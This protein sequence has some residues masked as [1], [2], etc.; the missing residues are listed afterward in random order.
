MY[1]NGILSEAG[2]HNAFEE[3]GE[4]TWLGDFDAE[5]I[6]AQLP[7]S[8][9]LEFD[10]RF[11]VEGGKLI[12]LTPALTAALPTRLNDPI[13]LSD[14]REIIVPEDLRGLDWRASSGV[15]N[16]YLVAVRF[17]ETQL[18]IHILRI[19][20]DGQ[21]QFSVV[22]IALN[23]SLNTTTAPVTAFRMAEGELGNITLQSFL[24]SSGRIRCNPVVF[25]QMESDEGGERI[26]IRYYGTS[27]SDFPG[28][29]NIGA[30]VQGATIGQSGQW[31]VT[32]MDNVEYRPDPPRVIPNPN[33]DPRPTIP[34]PNHDN[35]DP[36]SSPTMPNPNFDSRETLPNPLFDPSRAYQRNVHFTAVTQLSESF[37]RYLYVGIDVNSYS[38]NS[39]AI[40]RINANGT[41]T[42]IRIVKGFWMP[43]LA[44]NIRGF[45][46]PENHV[47]LARGYSPRL[48]NAVGQHIRLD[49]ET[50]MANTH[51]GVVYHNGLLHHLPDNARTGATLGATQI[52]NQLVT[53]WSVERLEMMPI[54]TSENFNG[55][56]NNPPRQLERRSGITAM[57]HGFS[58]IRN[59]LRLTID[60]TDLEIPSFGGFYCVPTRTIPNAR[61]AKFGIGQY[62]MVGA[63]EARHI[64]FSEEDTSD[65]FW[66]S[67]EQWPETREMRNGTRFRMRHYRSRGHFNQE[68]SIRNRSWNIIQS[69]PILRRTDSVGGTARNAYFEAIGEGTATIEHFSQQQHGLVWRN[70]IQHIRVTVTAAEIDRSESG[71]VRLTLDCGRLVAN[72][73]TK[74]DV[75]IQQSSY[76]LLGWNPP[77]DE[78]LHQGAFQL[79]EIQSDSSALAN[80]LYSGD[81]NI[82]VEA[83]TADSQEIKQSPQALGIFDA[84]IFGIE[85]ID[86][87]LT[88]AAGEAL[89]T[90]INDTKIA[91][92][93][94]SQV[95][96]YEDA[97]LL[98]FDKFTVYA[99]ATNRDGAMVPKLKILTPTLA[100]ASQTD[101][102]LVEMIDSA[103]LLRHAFSGLGYVTNILGRRHRSGIEETQSNFQDILV[104]NKHGNVPPPNSLTLPSGFLVQTPDYPQPVQHINA[105]TPPANI[106]EN[107]NAFRYSFPISVERGPNLDEWLRVMGNNA[108]AHVINGQMTLTTDVIGARGA[109]QQIVILGQLFEFDKSFLTPVNF[110]AGVRIFGQH[111]N[112]FNKIFAGASSQRAYFFDLIG[113]SIDAFQL[114][115]GFQTGI[116]LDLIDRVVDAIPMNEFSYTHVLRLDNEKGGVKNILLHMADSGV[117]FRDFGDIVPGP[118]SEMLVGI[119]GLLI[120]DEDSWRLLRNAVL[121]ENL[122]DIREKRGRF[123][124][125]NLRW[126]TGFVGDGISFINPRFWEVE[127]YL[128]TTMRELYEG[129]KDEPIRVRMGTY[130]LHDRKKW[131]QPEKTFAFTVNDFKDGYFTLRYDCL[132]EECRSQSLWFDADGFVHISA[133]TFK[134]IVGPQMTDR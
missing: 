115:S 63:F 131:S 48:R 113:K 27:L 111:T 66:I 49:P 81:T 67:T 24:S 33:H 44:G 134:Y 53:A 122:Q 58:F 93:A 5:R 12:W 1:N 82:P 57:F 132:H 94:P 106:R 26:T 130:S 20:P 96:V 4:G 73:P 107:I 61:L 65:P 9:V 103:Y 124:H 109:L 13:K 45:P 112:V 76:G 8:R 50:I 31:M 16:Q 119:G 74:E 64:S 59:A 38:L 108:Q 110:E 118:A 78:Q 32:A 68:R 69:T 80:I 40:I 41:F 47:T 29:P 62:S 43:D 2:L 100:V 10:K 19:D 75:S 18:H 79:S 99:H 71:E 14:G 85:G 60:G 28:L 36:H 54:R 25:G 123:F 55:V 88:M 102:N 133:L 87:Y 83:Q 17:G 21:P 95:I 30:I 46:F 125:Q 22:N 11:N 105:Y 117:F 91:T 37:D 39:C 116:P 70:H 120:Q 90:S 101:I 34:N 86:V 52:R 97:V 42:L 126:R 92:G 89:W 128:S 23:T 51:R 121:Y 104:E 3:R 84:W 72:Y 98:I 7:R 127:F 15:G 35:S 77:A 6:H 56:F 114:D 129:R